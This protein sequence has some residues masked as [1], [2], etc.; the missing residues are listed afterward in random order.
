MCSDINEKYVINE[1]HKDFELAI[2]AAA[3]IIYPEIRIKYW[4]RHQKLALEHKKNSL[5]KSDI[6]KNDNI[7]VL[8]NVLCNIY[9]C[10]PEYIVKVF[11]INKAKI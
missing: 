5:C 6:S 10:D 7:F 3:K 8:Y 9:L 4:I 2:W 1:L 11:K